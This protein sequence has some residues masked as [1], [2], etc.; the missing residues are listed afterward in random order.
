MVMMVKDI[1]EAG[2][3]IGSSRKFMRATPRHQQRTLQTR[4]M[5][6]HSA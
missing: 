4:T 1:A 6:D 3:R 5:E 2:R